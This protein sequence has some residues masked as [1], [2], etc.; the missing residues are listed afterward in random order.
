MRIIEF[1]IQDTHIHLIVEAADKQALSKG[2]QG[3]AIRLARAVNRASQRRGAVFADRYF[4]RPLKTPAEVR[5]AVSYV[6]RNVQK[7]HHAHPWYVDPYSSMSGHACW[8]VDER[9]CGAWVTAP[10][11]EWLT[12]RATAPPQ[13]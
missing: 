12:K 10:P 3:L 6:H 9:G 7:H 4:A 5:N 8:Y 1:S 2:M 13:Q 11:G